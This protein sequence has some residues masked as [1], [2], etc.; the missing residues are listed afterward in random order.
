MNM[1]PNGIEF[2]FVLQNMRPHSTAEDSAAHI[3]LQG[4]HPDVLIIR[5]DGSHAEGE[6]ARGQKLCS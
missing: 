4:E 6:R 5:Y 2:Q 3:E 1:V